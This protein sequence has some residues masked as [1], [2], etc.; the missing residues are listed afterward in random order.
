MRYLGLSTT[1][2]DRDVYVPVVRISPREMEIIHGLLANAMKHTPLTPE[3]SIVL[4]TMRTMNRQIIKFFRNKDHYM[5]AKKSQDE[6]G[7]QNYV[8]EPMYEAGDK[9]YAQ[10]EK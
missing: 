5:K 1:G 8:N 7:W 10:E 2:I 9:V 3:T 6:L 4:N